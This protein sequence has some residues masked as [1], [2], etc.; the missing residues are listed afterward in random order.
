MRTL[1]QKLACGC[2]TNATGRA[3]HQNYLL[4]KSSLH[5]ALLD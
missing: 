3:A 5:A 4:F 1:I 2:G